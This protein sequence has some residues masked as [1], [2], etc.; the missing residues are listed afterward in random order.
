MKLKSETEAPA[1]GAATEHAETEVRAD[2]VLA[3]TP[4]SSTQVAAE[5]TDYPNFCRT[6]T[7]HAALAELCA[8]PHR[9][10]PSSAACCANTYDDEPFA[11]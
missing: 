5:C 9:V 7:E 2:D 4:R 3:E 10:F 11:V 8:D 1:G 6:A